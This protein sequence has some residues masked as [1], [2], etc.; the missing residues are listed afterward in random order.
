MGTHTAN[1]VTGDFSV[2]AVGHYYSSGERVPF[3]GV[4]LSGN[5]FDLLSSVRALGDDLT[6]HG[7]Y[8]SPTLMIEGLKIS[9]KRR[10]TDAIKLTSESSMTRTGGSSSSA[11]VIAASKAGAVLKSISPPMLTTATPSRC[12]TEVVM[13]PAAD[14][15]SS[16]IGCAIAR[17]G[18]GADPVPPSQT[19]RNIT[20]T[21]RP[22]RLG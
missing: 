3:K 17:G 14:K 18:P 16:L 9:G 7:S 11:P 10:P 4:I 12:A 1:P 20:S 19:G 22:A 2:G 21:P 8:G 6:F 5:L 13:G 15:R